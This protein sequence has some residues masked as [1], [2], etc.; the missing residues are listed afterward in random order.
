MFS[1]F[2]YL[3]KT[4]RWDVNTNTVSIPR[5]PEAVFW[6]LKKC[7]PKYGSLEFDRLDPGHHRVLLW[8]GLWSSRA[9][10][11]VSPGQ[12]RQWSSNRAMHAPRGTGRTHPRDI[13]TRLIYGNDAPDPPFLVDSAEA[14]L[15]Q[16]PACGPRS[17]QRPPL[18]SH[19]LPPHRAG[20]P[21]ALFLQ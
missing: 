2:E 16:N 1:L 11:L 13:E 3:C 5:H 19:L 15:P 20:R 8:V 17:R 9:P 4:Q 21:L 12:S 7:S 6:K 18:S 10:L 14:H